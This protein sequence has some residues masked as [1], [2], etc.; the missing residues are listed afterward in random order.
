MPRSDIGL[1]SRRPTLYGRR[2]AI[3]AGHYLAAAAGFSILEA[4]GNAIDA[5]CAAGVSLAVVCPFEV[6]AG[7]VAPI[8]IRAADGRVV[9]LAGLGSW[10]RSVPADLFVREHHGKI[11]D[12]LLQT[13]VPAAPDAWITALRDFG[14][15]TFGDV[16]SEAIRFARD[17]FAVYDFF[18]ECVAAEASDYARWPSNA[19]VFLPNGRAPAVGERF[20]QADLAATLQYMVDEERAASSQGRDAGLE[21]ARGAFYTGEIAERIVSYHDSHGGHL[22]REDLASFRTPREPVVRVR[23]R[24]FEVFTC[25]PWCQGPVLAQ[26]LTMIEEIGLT[27]TAI[28]DPGYAHLV[29]EVLKAAFA[30]REYRYGDPNFI[31]VRVDELLSPDHVAARVAAIDPT[32]AYPELPPP[33]GADP[34]LVELLPEPVPSPTLPGLRDTSYVCVVDRWGN[35]FSA[36][37]SDASSQSPVIPGTG[38]VPSARGNQSRPDPRHPAGV[39]PGRRPRLTPNPAMAVREDGSILAFGCPGGD[40]QA[41]AMLQ[42]FLNAF[43]FGMDVQDAINAP[44]VSTWSFPNSFAPFDY[45]P[46]HVAIEGRYGEDLF[47]E[48]ERRGHDVERWPDFTRS[49]AAVEAIFLDATSGFLHAGADPRQPAYAIVG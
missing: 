12:G 49:A 47:A 30:D 6:S 10:P 14:T 35:A 3:A 4:G 2:H 41:Q 17:G 24:D 21:A 43:H 13:V 7:G 25:G 32:R 18:A 36:T 33:I 34:S 37:P 38:L 11:P 39:G 28:D 22:T 8:M 16:A 9:T 45:L 5:G 31:D 29:I 15:M 44:R 42:F 26:A 20:V 27:A 48:L 46:N 19:A 40:M 23:W 1:A